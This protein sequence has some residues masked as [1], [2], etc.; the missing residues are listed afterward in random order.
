MK[1]TSPTIAALTPQRLTT[2]L[3]EHSPGVA[4][5]TVEIIETSTYGA[6]TV[7]TADR[8][9]LGLE[10]VAGRDGGLPP[11]MLLKTFIDEPHAPHVMYRTEARFY[12]TVRPELGIETP[13]AFG[14]IND[15]EAGRFGVLLEDLSLRDARF[16]NA[17]TPITLDEIS[18]LVVSLAEL[19]ARYWA[20]PRFGGDLDWVATPR[21]GGMSK[22]F[23]AIGLELVRDQL[24]HEFKAELVA[25]LGRSA[26]ALWESLWRL[27]AIIDSEPATLLHGDP[28]IG[29]TYIL[30]S[31]RGGFIDWQLLVRGRW[32]HD[33]TYLL[34]TGLNTEQRRAHERELIAMYRDELQRR[35][36]DAPSDD[37]AWLL[38]RQAAVWGL[39]IGWLITPPL[40]YGED[41]TAANLS[42]L[43]TAVRDLESFAA[44]D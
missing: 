15:E 32:A 29:N 11:R 1:D 39:V 16:P 7:S 35:G 37:E 8:V 4:V 14:S 22:T 40:N 24:R 44:L 18:S 26:E 17:T 13:R 21:S 9:T 43:V 28:H 12:A 42:R 2:A 30:P 6:G 34:I 33:V 20:S 31:G 10:Y 25:P 38:Y 3:T 41:I 5:R 19:H 23:N 27:Q 36:V